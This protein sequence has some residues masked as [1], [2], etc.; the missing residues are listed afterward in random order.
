MLVREV[1]HILRQLAGFQCDQKI[2]VIDQLISGEVQQD[3]TVLHSSEE[4]LVDH[5]LRRI[6]GR[7]VQGD[8]IA[9]RQHFGKILINGDALAA[10]YIIRVITD[11]LHAERVGSLCDL[12]A[13]R[14]QADDAERFAQDFMTCKL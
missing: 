9:E 6:V 7:Q 13:D 8:D 10:G 12:A 14:T 3:R 11:D 4:C 1:G 2:H 5:A